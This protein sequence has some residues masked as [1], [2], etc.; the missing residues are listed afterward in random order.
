MLAARIAVQRAD[1]LRSERSDASQANKRVSFNHDI[2]VKHINHQK[3]NRIKGLAPLPPPA[4]SNSSVAADRHDIPPVS[5][6]YN[7]Y[8]EPTLL[9]AP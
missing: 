1:S 4:S 7:V 5:P 3:Q 9:T 8:K 2:D 6:F